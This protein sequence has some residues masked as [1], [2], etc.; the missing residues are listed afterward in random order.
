MR[1]YCAPILLVSILMTG[2]VSFGQSPNRTITGKVVDENNNPIADVTI[3][4]KGNEAHTS[5]LDNG[6]FSLSAPVGTYELELSLVGYK[7]QTLK[8]RV[9]PGSDLSLNTIIL[10]SQDNELE[11]LT[12]EGKTKAKALKE[13]A[14][15]INVIDAKKLYNSSADLNQALNKTSGVRVREDGGVG[16]NFSFSL[17]GFSGKQVKFFLDGI[18]M[19]NFGSSL[20]LNNFP[21]NMAERIE[22]YKGVLPIHLGADALGGAVNLVTRSNPNFLDVSYGYGSFNTHKAAL[23]HAYT[24]GKTGFTIRTNAFYNFS[25]NN[26]KVNV[27]PIVLSG[28]QSGQRAPTQ[29]VE[30]F[31]DGYE[32]AT[33]QVEAGVSGKRYADQL[34]IG[35]IASGND[36][37]IQTGVTMDQVFGART[38]TSNSL[39]PTLKY[40]KA[41]LFIKGLDL[42]LYTAYNRS[43]HKFIDTTRLK[44]NWLQETIPTSTA[45]LSRSQLKNKDK[46]GLITANL[47][48]ALHQNHA[49]SFNY[50]M[51]DFRR[52]SSD[53]ENPNNVTFLYPQELNKQIMGLAW[54]A[55]YDKFTATAFSKLYLLDA[56]SFEQVANGTGVASY[57]ESTTKTNEIG[58]GAAMAYFLL[59]KLQAKASFEHT[60]RLP[61]AVE[62]LGDGLY[63]RRNAALK[64]ESSDNINLGVLYAF[65]FTTDHSVNLEANYIFRNAQD[66]IRLDQAQTQPIDRQYVNIGDVRTNGVEGE[67]RYS[68]ENKFQASL[69]VTYQNIIDKERFLSSTNL[70]GTTTTPNRGYGY[71]IPNM[72]YLFGNAD[73]GYTFNKIGTSNN[74]LSINYSLNYVEKY[75]LTP[76][77][78]GTGNQ[79]VIPSQFAHNVMANYT[80]K[81]GK[82]NISLECRNLADNNLF[83]NYKLQKPGRSVFLK[84]RYFISN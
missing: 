9:V 18:P 73:V 17:N 38:S 66:Y 54:Q 57:Q 13:Q 76:Q 41:D 44:F 67:I 64:P 49:V 30:R 71:R 45:E 31:H 42:S 72:P 50:V 56:N 80:V 35:V 79:D 82:Y 19:D 6:Q 12:I 83:D 61:E 32:S 29:E 16:S 10:Q 78:L 63:T 46:E 69:N 5:T 28:A 23:S 27:N 62:L 58:Y 70:T 65:D 40:K 11:E 75:Y 48:Y 1:N 39:I 68:W 4:L 2:F 14:F 55:N 7:K 21:I 81:N 53:V 59:P 74:N 26:Y 24:N 52:K 33:V 3:S 15:N 43:N 25:D 34:L 36:R 77:H 47:A 20:T 22:I 60:Y 84:L 8:V 51:T 37:D